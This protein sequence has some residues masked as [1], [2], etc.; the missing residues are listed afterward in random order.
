MDTR[1]LRGG[2]PG[3]P[4]SPWSRREDR[5]GVSSSDLKSL[6]KNKNVD[7]LSHTQ[8][9][10]CYFYSPVQSVLLF[11]CRLAPMLVARTVKKTLSTLIY[12]FEARKS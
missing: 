10:K 1:R 3:R 9:F 8:H 6:W 5:P 4:G 2:R 7:K 12:S 11:Y